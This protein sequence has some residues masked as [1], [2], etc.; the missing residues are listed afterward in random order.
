MWLHISICGKYTTSCIQ[1]P[2]AQA[3]DIKGLSPVRR[4]QLSTAT[5][6][7]HPWAT[8][9]QHQILLHHHQCS[10]ARRSPLYVWCPRVV[11]HCASTVI[12]LILTWPV[13]CWVGGLVCF[14]FSRGQ[15]E[16]GW[17]GM[18]Q[19]RVGWF[20]FLLSSSPSLCPS[21]H[22]VFYLCLDIMF[23]CSSLNLSHFLAI[24]FC[25][26]CC[27]PPLPHP[28]PFSLFSILSLHLSASHCCD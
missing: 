21:L 22:L 2:L 14:V 26:L 19:D 28:L 16:G 13:S 6:P 27:F 12:P 17:D 7:I 1:T 20:L 4:L 9:H 24:V 5:Q 11:P 23:T 3:C 25:P 15:R 18:G 10:V 8:N